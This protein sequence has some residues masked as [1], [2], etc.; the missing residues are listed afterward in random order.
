MIQHFF[1]FLKRTFF[2]QSGIFLRVQFKKIS[3]FCCS[4]QSFNFQKITRTLKIYIFWQKPSLYTIEQSQKTKL[5]IKTFFLFFLF[6]Q[7]WAKL[8]LICTRDNIVFSFSQ[9]FAFKQPED[10]FFNQVQ[11]LKC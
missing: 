2:C 8:F 9:I 7:K 1:R 5:E 6:Y 3:N 4:W 11:P 10:Q